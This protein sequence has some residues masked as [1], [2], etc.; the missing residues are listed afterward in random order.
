[1]ALNATTS[2]VFSSGKDEIPGRWSW[3]TLRGKNSIKTTIITGY[4][5][6][7]NSHGHNNVYLQQ[8][9]YLLAKQIEDCPRELWLQD[10]GRFIKNKL[11]N[12]HQIILLTDMND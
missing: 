5:P 9:R 1:M 8:Q 12:A 11:Q 7:D 4:R 6:C 10:M 2:R 3:I